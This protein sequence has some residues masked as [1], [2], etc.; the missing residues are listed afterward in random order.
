MEDATASP[1]QMPSVLVA[2]VALLGSAWEAAT[3][4]RTRRWMREKPGRI[5]AALAGSPTG[6]GLLAMPVWSGCD[7]GPSGAK[8]WMSR[9]VQADALPVTKGGA[10]TAG[11][12]D[13][14]HA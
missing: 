14:Y 10:R 13:G 3:A 5:R 1:E 9:T 11:I 6:E 7:R 12:R 2:D 4:K 8:R